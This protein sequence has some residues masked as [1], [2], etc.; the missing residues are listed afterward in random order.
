ML[1]CVLRVPVCS[2]IIAAGGNSLY[3]A[4]MGTKQPRDLITDA[5]VVHEP[6]WAESVA[7]AADKQVGML[8]ETQ[9]K[10]IVVSSL[11]PSRTMS[12]FLGNR[13]GKRHMNRLL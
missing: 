3:V 7:L 2:Y 4:F 1:L 11:E 12:I 8:H 10:A 9:T 6:V 13:D 5:N